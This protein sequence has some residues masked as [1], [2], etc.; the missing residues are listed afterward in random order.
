MDRLVVGHTPHNLNIKP[1]RSPQ[2]DPFLVSLCISY[3][4]QQ[5]ERERESFL[6]LFVRWDI[7]DS[8]TICK[9]GSWKPDDS[10]PDDSWEVNHSTH[11]AVILQKHRGRP[12]AI[13]G[14]V[15][16]RLRDEGGSL[17]NSQSHFQISQ[18]TLLILPPNGPKWDVLRWVSPHGGD[19]G[20]LFLQLFLWLSGTELNL[21]VSLS[22][23]LLWSTWMLEIMQKRWTNLFSHRL[24]GK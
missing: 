7:K 17:S 11:D 8:V 21:K 22:V 13:P 19:S 18:R 5:A 16:P 23:T 24:T 20:K 6:F 1:R 14:N 2:T 12:L 4:S 3:F 15:P 10:Q 9:M